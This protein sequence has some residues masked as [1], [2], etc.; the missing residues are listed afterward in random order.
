[1]TQAASSSLHMNGKPTILFARISPENSKLGKEE[2]R[3]Q[4]QQ[5]LKR[6][7][8]NGE[9]RF[10]L[11]E[12]LPATIRGQAVTL[13]VYEGRDDRGVETRQIFSDALEGKS[14]PVIL[15]ISG[16]LQGWDQAEIDRFLHSIQ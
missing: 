3:F 11:V 14:G 15:F 7:M 16:P 10:D 6:A 8:G 9:V 4:I 5:G 1:M 2:L 13:Y 12:Q